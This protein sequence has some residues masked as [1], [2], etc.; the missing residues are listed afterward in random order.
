[1]TR[2]EAYAEWWKKITSDGDP[3]RNPNL[4]QDA[5]KAGWDAAENEARKERLVIARE[6]SRELREAIAETVWQERQGGE[7]GSY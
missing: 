4:M 2:A 6:H 1:M 3:D 7:Y 5:F